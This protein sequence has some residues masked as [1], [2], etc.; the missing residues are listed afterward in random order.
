MEKI[1]TFQ[2]DLEASAV[3]EKKLNRKELRKIYGGAKAGHRSM[4][5]RNIASRKIL[6]MPID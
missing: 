5:P 6:P 1:N 4:A 3:L 2:K